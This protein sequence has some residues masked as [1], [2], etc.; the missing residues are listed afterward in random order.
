MQKLIVRDC[1]IQNVARV[2]EEERPQ[3]SA[4]QSFY[5]VFRESVNTG[6]FCGLALSSDINQ[7]P[8]W[9]FADLTEHRKNVYVTPNIRVRRALKL[10]DE[11]GLD[12]LPVLE[13][14]IFLGVVTRQS[15]VEAL[16]DQE[17]QCRLE[18]TKL[19]K[20]LDA[21]HEQIIVWSDKLSE[22][23]TASRSLLTVL[24]HT[25]LQTDLLQSGIESLTKLLEAHYGAISILDDDGGLKHFVFTGMTDEQ[26]Q[27]IGEFP[28][29]KGLLG[30][31]IQ[32]NLSLR[33]TDM[34]R[35]PQSI[36]FPEHHPALFSS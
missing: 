8:D 12:V 10:M 20:L 28:Q 14:K 29:G 32:E 19:I 35:H 9:I 5:A 4:I 6:F 33:L 21:K 17:H 24:G 1:L 23:H 2:L 16:L 30:L 13:R 26:A 15:I 3:F 36:G 31:V 34:S 22:L 7:H 27:L 25:S 18:T 11:H